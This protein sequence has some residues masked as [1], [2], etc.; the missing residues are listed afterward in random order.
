MHYGWRPLVMS[1][2]V[3]FTSLV[4]VWFRPSPPDGFGEAFG[5][6][7]SGVAVLPPWWFHFGVRAW[8]SDWQDCSRHSADVLCRNLQYSQS[9]KE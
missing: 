1:G 6:P 3:I 2:I 8:P 4:E 7:F 5:G 9:L